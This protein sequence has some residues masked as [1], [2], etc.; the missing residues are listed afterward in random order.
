VPD[1]LDELR[2]AL[3]RLPL[4]PAPAADVRRLGDRRRR[5]NASL[6][7]AGALLAVAAAASPLALD[8]GEHPAASSGP[9]APSRSWARTVP[10]GFPLSQGMAA[11]RVA[12]PG[13]VQACSGVTAWTSRNTVST[14]G[15]RSAAAGDGERRVLALYPDDSAAATALADAQRA[16]ISCDARKVPAGT[17]LPQELETNA[18]EDSFAFVDPD[19]QGWVVASF[20]RVGSAL[21]LDLAPAPALPVPSG[22]DPLLVSGQTVADEMARKATGVVSSMCVFAAV[23]CPSGDPSTT[24]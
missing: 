5:R 9:S 15:T 17:L 2:D 20:T 18:G 11:P 23:P 19:Q 21:L 16:L 4:H 13:S 12:A 22:A 14:T 6:V 7:G 10:N 24:P 1:T 3:T 8:G